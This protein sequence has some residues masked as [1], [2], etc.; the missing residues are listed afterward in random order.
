MQV[1]TPNQELLQEKIEFFDADLGVALLIVQG[2]SQVAGQGSGGLFLALGK[3]T[4]VFAVDGLDGAQGKGFV[5]NGHYQDLVGGVSRAG[6]PTTVEFQPG[7][8]TGQ[9]QVVVGISH[10][11]GFLFTHGITDDAVRRNGQANFREIFTGLDQGYQLTLPPVVGKDTQPFG[12]HAGG[13]FRNH[14][15]QG[16]LQVPGFVYPGADFL[17]IQALFQILPFDRG[18]CLHRC[19]PHSQPRDPPDE[20]DSIPLFSTASYVPGDPNPRLRE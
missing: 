5:G 4:A 20:P 15:S 12:I 11:Q 16:F 8:Y 7:V 1:L 9:L 14:G 18:I 13:H 17:Q 10:P 6:I 3:R 19:H 2:C